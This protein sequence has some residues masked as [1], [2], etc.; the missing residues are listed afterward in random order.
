M[1]PWPPGAS[2]QLKRTQAEQ[3]GQISH[4]RRVGTQVPAAVGGAV[5]HTPACMGA[6]LRREGAGALY[7]CMSGP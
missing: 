7:R 4:G 1:N 3:M 5:A 2:Q 6:E